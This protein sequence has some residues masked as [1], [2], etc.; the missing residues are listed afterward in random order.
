MNRRRSDDPK[1]LTAAFLALGLMAVTGTFGGAMH[2]IYRN[3]QIKTERQIADARE[4][5]REHRLDMQMYEVRRERELDRYE[6]RAD[7][8]HFES[9][10][11]SVSHG[12]VEKVRPLPAPDP[13]P[14][15][16]RP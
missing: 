7:L 15:A 16:L 14:V 8:E 3:G 1:S 12:V 13:A 9:K 10:L 2:A 5:I 6:I 11:V 4:R